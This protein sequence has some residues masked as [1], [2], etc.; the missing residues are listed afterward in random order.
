MFRIMT[1]VSSFIVIFTSFSSYAEPQHWLAKKGDKEYMII[2]SVHVGD[3]SMYPLPKALIQHLNKSSGLIIEADVRNA[4]GVLYPPASMRTKDVLNE[5]QRQHLIKIAN[6][7]D[8]PEPQLLNLPPWNTALT[9]QLALINKL[10]YAAGEGVDMRMINLA[11]KNNLPILSLESVQFQVDLITGQPDEGKELLL[12]SINEYDAGEALVECLI[13]SWKSGDGSML[14]EA[15]LLDQATQEFNEAF[16][17]ARNR[18]WARKLDTGSILPHNRG[19]YT[20]VVGGL[21][22]VGKH[23]LIDLLAERGFKIKPL[24]Q[25]RRAKCDFLAGPSS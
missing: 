25:T 15:S 22:L 7:L 20:V 5:T 13:E 16:L 8:L 24:G 18:D 2:G 9:I 23:N 6:E 10:G 19:R 1:F 11:E 3:K 12:S 17:Y 21:H 14:E 4:Q